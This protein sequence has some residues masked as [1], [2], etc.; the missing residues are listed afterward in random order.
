MSAVF[1][2]FIFASVFIFNFFIFFLWINKIHKITILLSFPKDEVGNSILDEDRLLDSKYDMT[3]IISEEEYYNYYSKIGFTYSSARSYSSTLNLKYEDAF[4]QPVLLDDRVVKSCSYKLLNFE[5]LGL[6]S[7]EGMS[8]NDIFGERRISKVKYY[9]ID[10]AGIYLD[11][12][13]IAEGTKWADFL[14]SQFSAQKANVNIKQSADFYQI[15]ITDNNDANNKKSFIIF[16]EQHF[17]R[18]NINI[19]SN[20]SGNYLKPN[21]RYSLYSGDDLFDV[22]DVEIDFSTRKALLAGFYRHAEEDAGYI[23]ALESKIYW[24]DQVE[25]TESN[26]EVI[27][28]VTAHATRFFKQVDDNYVEVPTIYHI[29]KE[30]KY[31]YIQNDAYTIDTLSN[32]YDFGKLKIYYH[33][34]TY[35]DGELVLNQDQTFVKEGYAAFKFTEDNQQ[36]KVSFIDEKN[37]E[38]SRLCTLKLD[39]L[40]EQVNNITNGQFWYLYHNRTDCPLLFDHA[41]TIEAE[42]TS[43]WGQAHSASFGCEY[44]LPPSWQSRVDGGT[45]YFN[46]HIIKIGNDNQVFLSNW[47]LPE[48]A[49]YK[50]NNQTVLPKYTLEYNPAPGNEQSLINGGEFIYPN[51]KTSASHVLNSKHPISLALKELQETLGNI[52]VNKSNSNSQFGKTTY[53]YNKNN[54]TGIRWSEFIAKHSSESFVYNLYSGNH[55][56]TYNILKNNFS[57]NYMGNYESRATTTSLTKTIWKLSWY[58]IRKFV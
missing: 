19:L 11:T 47:Y 33:Q 16:K 8:W 1:S 31:F 3:S 4:L 5:D 28:T 46:N 17:I 14:S 21:K 45:N 7:N 2:C 20:W 44:F 9:F 34:E 24:E 50:E 56:M 58:I 52:V 39:Q 48:V 38:F 12:S 42:L 25:K 53:F 54:I 41:A 15:T 18:K 26:G 23:P 32:V 35:Q 10:K 51:H 30:N 13:E 27:E 57:E 22:D 29:K 55:I 6:A 36:I 49:I 37:I 40:G 43:Y